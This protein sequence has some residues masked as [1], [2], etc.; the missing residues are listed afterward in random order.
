MKYNLDQYKTLAERFNSKSFLGKLMLIKQTP[1]LFTLEVSDGNFFLRLNDD[2]AQK[3]ELD[4]LFSFPSILS[5]KEFKD[6]FSLL[7]IKIKII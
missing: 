2:E 6:L 1:D 5:D 7:D 3:N 4:M